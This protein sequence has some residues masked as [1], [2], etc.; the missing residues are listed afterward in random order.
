MTAAEAPDTLAVDP[1]TYTLVAQFLAH[2]ARLLDEG[3]EEEWFALLDDELLYTVPARRSTEPRSMEVDRTAWRI[4]DTKAHIRTRI[5]RTNT[6][7]A[8]SEVPPSR[9]MR[10]VGGVEVRTTDEPGVV[11]AYSSLLLYRQRGIDVHFDLVP[12]RRNDRVRLTDAGPR[13]LSREVI[14]T[15]TSLKTANLGVFL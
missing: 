4:R 7:H 14:L 12:C 11:E 13:L 1:A 8:Y 6:G 5:A 3:R 9:T 2:E 10:L 15:E